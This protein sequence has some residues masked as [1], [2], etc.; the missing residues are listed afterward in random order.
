MMTLNQK[1]RQGI[2]IDWDHYVLVSQFC[3]LSYISH[4]G[5]WQFVSAY[6]L[7]NPTAE[8]TFMDDWEL[9][10]YVLV[11]VAL[12]HLPHSLFAGHLK[13][14]LEIFD[15]YVVDNRQCDVESG[16]KQNTLIANTFSSGLGLKVPGL[17]DCLAILCDTFAACH[18][19]II[20]N[21]F[22]SPKTIALQHAVQKESLTQ[23]ENPS[24]F[25]TTLRDFTE[26]IKEPPKP[27]IDWCD[28]MEMIHN[29][30]HTRS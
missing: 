16:A 28:N 17:E 7:K 15:A 18:V 30:K 22:K 4:T 10:L 29:T 8:H 20:E 24:W 19:K 1:N 11:W 12:H 27:D 2:L 26:E 13:A 21:C 6:L 25:Y 23:L 5:T 14:T 9:A 3:D